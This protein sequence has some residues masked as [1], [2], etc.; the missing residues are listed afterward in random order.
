MG[1]ALSGGGFRATLFHLGSLKRLNELGLLPRVKTITG[2]SGG[3]IAAALLGLRWSSI[4]F[5]PNGAAANLPELIIEPLR[6]LCSKDIQLGPGILNIF[7]MLFG[8]PTSGLAP[9]YRRYLFGSATLGD[10]TDENA[11]PDVILLASNLQ[12]GGRV[13]FSCDGLREERLGLLHFPEIPLATAV[14]ASSAFPPFLSPIVLETDLSRWSCSDKSDLFDESHLRS[15]LVLTDGGMHDPVGLDPILD[16]QDRY[17]TILVSDASTTRQLWR[18]PSSFWPRQTGRSTIMQTVSHGASFRKALMSGGGFS[19]SIPASKAAAGKSPAIAWW[20]IA[21][22]IADYGIES[23]LATDTDSTRELGA[24]RSVLS[25]FS[26]EE[27]G[28]LID[29]GYALCD[30]ATR[31]LA[32]TQIH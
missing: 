5:D 16:T 20:N 23:P 7:A 31:K 1:L 25:P 6:F 9:E 30:A 24:M 2:V 10:L 13:W 17:D 26:R 8:L 28:R 27:Q 19:Q 32:A 15:R 12:T 21:D 29:W 4:A 18:K 11:G 22:R 3:S 14:A